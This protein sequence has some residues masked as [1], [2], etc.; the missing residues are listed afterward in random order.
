MD[1]AS[2]VRDAVRRSAV[3]LLGV[4][5]LTVA[6]IAEELF[7]D[8]RRLSRRR[9]DVDVAAQWQADAERFASQPE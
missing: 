9:R 8:A 5:E 6:G 2:A 3:E 7:N 4:D 1:G